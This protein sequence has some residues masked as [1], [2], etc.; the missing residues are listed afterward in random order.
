M[1]IFEPSITHSPSRRAPWSA[2]RRRRSRLG[3]SQPE[4]REALAE[5]SRGSHSRTLAIV[6]EELIGI[7][8]SSMRGDRD[9]ERRVDARSS[10]MQ[11]A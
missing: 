10:S 1:N 8:R 2:W 6:A 5:A 7:V 9:R 11:S 4:R 3:L